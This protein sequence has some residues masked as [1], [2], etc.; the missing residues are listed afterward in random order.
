MA[1]LVLSA[2]S[3]LSACSTVQPN[4]EVSLSQAT[5]DAAIAIAADKVVWDIALSEVEIGSYRPG[6]KV[7]GAVVVH[8]GTDGP[9]NF[10]LSYKPSP[11][12]PQEWVTISEPTF[13]LGPMESKVVAISFQTPP[14]SE[15]EADTLEFRIL[16]VKAQT[17]PVQV[18]YE[19]K[20]VISIKGANK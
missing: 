12:I 14:F 18:A 5:I 4:K 20:W 1:A 15:I 10:T 3:G 7:N 2:L 16:V 9:G 8:E 6:V 19:Q 17:T 11:N 13:S